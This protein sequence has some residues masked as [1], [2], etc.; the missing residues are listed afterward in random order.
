MTILP[1]TTLSRMTIADGDLLNQQV[2]SAL[3]GNDIIF[4]NELSALSANSYFHDPATNSIYHFKD[5]D[6]NGE[7]VYS[8]SAQLLSAKNLYST[9]VSATNVTATNTKSTNVTANNVTATNTVTTNLSAISENVYM[10]SAN[11]TVPQKLVDIIQNLLNKWNSIDNYIDNHEAAWSSISAI[12][13]QGMSAPFTG[14]TFT[15]DAGENVSFTPQGNDTVQI[16]A[17]SQST[18]YATNKRQ[19][20]EGNYLYKLVIK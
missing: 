1:V 12:S 15:L 8:F 16:N 5:N 11:G 20:G 7:K 13:A 14:N 6:P 19:Y 2:V 4:A 3:S 9:N 17:A 18:I 10:L